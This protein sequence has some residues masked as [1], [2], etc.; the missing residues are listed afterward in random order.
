MTAERERIV[1]EARTWIDVRWRHQGR[2]R[3]AGIDCAGLIICVGRALG[4]LPPDF[5]VRG[6]KREPDGRTLADLLSANAAQKTLAD[7]QPG[8]FVLLRDISTVWPCHM[9]FLADRRGSAEPNLIHSWARVHR[10]CV[11][12]R[13]D[14]D[15]IDRI[16]GVY[17]FHGVA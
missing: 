2:S 11:E 9:G 14:Q 10:K 3:A 15:W 4:Y 17:S 16:D 8:D 7:W 13:L 5:D 6:Y 12:V 1:A